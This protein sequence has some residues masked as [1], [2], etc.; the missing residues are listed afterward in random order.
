MRMYALAYSFHTYFNT[1]FDSMKI[2]FFFLLIA[3]VVTTTSF[4]QLRVQSAD[5]KAPMSRNLDENNTLNPGITL[6]LTEKN[7][8]LE[9][10]VFGFSDNGLR[11]STGIGSSNTTSYFDSASNSFTYSER[12]RY[13][14][15]PGD[16]VLTQFQ[17]TYRNA[18]GIRIGLRTDYSW[19]NIPF[20]SSLSVGL[21]GARASYHRS[22]SYQSL[23]TTI[24]FGAQ[25]FD[26]FEYSFPGTNFSSETYF[27]FIPQVSAQLGVILSLNE[28]IKVIPKLAANMTYGEYLSCNLAGETSSYRDLD[29]SMAA[30][31]S[32]FILTT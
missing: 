22:E 9:L 32:A 14:L 15:E 5:F 19:G 25:G 6:E 11:Y 31:F 4:G 21:V 8:L 20:Y 27:S 13:N 30:S 23:D 3:S 1:Y 16:S 7:K 18:L 17:S 28:R 29:F 12:P 10:G 2:K 26:R 24:L